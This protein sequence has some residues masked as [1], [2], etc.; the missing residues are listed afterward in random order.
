MLEGVFGSVSRGLGAALSDEFIDRVWATEIRRQDA[1]GTFDARRSRM[2]SQLVV[3]QFDDK[4]GSRCHP[5]LLAELSG[6]KHASVL[7][8]LRTTRFQIHP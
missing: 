3:D 5:Q 2:D 7:A 6:N 4:F 8:R 1:P